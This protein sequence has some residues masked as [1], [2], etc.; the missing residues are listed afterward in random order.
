[1]RQASKKAES[2]LQDR[3]GAQVLLQLTGAA[4]QGGSSHA[5]SNDTNLPRSG[6]SMGNMIRS[7][8][9]SV[10]QCCSADM[11]QPHCGRAEVAGARDWDPLISGG[12]L[13]HCL[14]IRSTG[15]DST[16][17]SGRQ[18]GSM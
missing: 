14:K 17:S 8:S 6:S 16:A 7:H 2:A 1:M 11:Q 9:R 15:A 12:D 18:F 10:A 3:T 13:I 4:L 5:G